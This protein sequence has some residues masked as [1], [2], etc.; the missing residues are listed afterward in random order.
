MTGF[1]RTPRVSFVRPATAPQPGGALRP[2]LGVPTSLWSVSVAGVA[3]LLG[4]SGCDSQ[5]ADG[6][7]NM[8]TAPFGSPNSNGA[9]PNGTTNVTG[10]PGPGEQR[11]PASLSSIQNN[12]PTVDANG[13]PLPTEMLAP[14]T[15]CSTPGPRQIRRL[16]S[17]QYRNTLLAVFGGDENVPNAPVLRDAT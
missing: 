10:L 15:M 11:T 12:G 1:S 17:A 14:L 3:A 7:P 5:L 4:A 16:T 9:N 2:R 6:N 13:A 8:M